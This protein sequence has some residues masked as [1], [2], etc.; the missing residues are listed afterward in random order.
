[1]VGTGDNVLIVGFVVSGGGAAATK[2]V[3]I[4]GTGPTLAGFGVAGTLA[5]P[6]LTL[7][8][9]STVVASNDNWGGNAQ[10]TSE[11]AAAQAFPLSNPSSLDSALYIPSL[12]SNLYSALISG[13]NNGTGVALAEVYDLTSSGSYNPATTPRLTSL[14]SRVQ[15][16]T[17]DNVLIAGFVIGG[18]S[19]KT[20][21]IRASGPALNQ[22]GV[23]GTLPDP[24]LTLYRSD[25]TAIVTN[26]G[27]GG[28]PQIANTAA[29]VYAFTWTSTSSSDSA[30][31]ITL[32]PGLYSA[33]ISGASNDTGVALVEVY[34]VP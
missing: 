30:L 1:M 19:A 11:D 21:L 28:D 8:Q 24:L 14:S 7:Y 25:S 27:W 9:G 32:P 22:F 2:P 23:S 33:G 16:G 20:M 15:V 5:D 6:L 10:I 31:L 29:S 26:N 3:L 17:G 18:S 4:R 13:N 34:E 12:A